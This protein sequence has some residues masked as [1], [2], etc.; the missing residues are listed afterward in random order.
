MATLVN[1][2]GLIFR[3]TYNG[4][5]GIDGQ[6]EY[7]S[8]QNLVVGK[9]VA[10]QI[11]SGKSY[12]VDK[13]DHWAFYPHEKHIRYWENFPIPVFLFLHNPEDD[14][15]YFTD[16]K[17]YFGIPKKEK[18]NYIPVSKKSILNKSAK[19]EIFRSFGDID[20][21]LMALEEVLHFLINT[22]SDNAS[23]LISYFD[24]FINGLTNLCRQLY[25]SISVA[26][27]IAEYNMK[28]IN[29]SEF[30]ISVGEGEHEFLHAFVR[31]LIEQNLA[32]VDYGDYLIDWEERK[33]QPDFLATIT[34]RGRE[35]FD[36]IKASEHKLVPDDKYGVNLV[37]E[38]G[39][40]MTY[41][42]SDMVR[43]KKSY[44]YQQKYLGIK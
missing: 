18:P 7:V 9:I 24:L 2:L 14:L 20:K 27:D 23:F 32:K 34:S 25:F 21:P 36:I 43:M 39:M 26:Y 38:R 10:A 6:I 30:G 28:E 4:D 40:A 35:L 29:H 5:V 13:G 3:E 11:K 17:Y 31:F 41:L 44:E 15:V 42:P 33:L 22:R 37:C 16:V 1:K 12:F 19:Q 8:S